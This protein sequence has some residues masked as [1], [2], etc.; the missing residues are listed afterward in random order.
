MNYWI[1]NSER[2]QKHI[3]QEGED[4]EK[5]LRKE[6]SDRLRFADPTLKKF[7]KTK[8]QAH[9][10]NHQAAVKAALANR[11]NA[12]FLRSVVV[13]EEELHS[14]LDQRASLDHMIDSTAA[15]NPIGASEYLSTLSA[16]DKTDKRIKETTK[17]LLDRLE[18][19]KKD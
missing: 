12:V 2:F 17:D 19:I 1:D 16:R 18:R 11:Y 15:T 6:M 3:V 14:L 7:A 13:V 10:E 5:R 8:Y 9:F 4:G